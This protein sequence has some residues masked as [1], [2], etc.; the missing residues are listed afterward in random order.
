[1]N[2]LLKFITCGS[3]D[4]GKSTLIGRMLCDAKLIFKEQEAALVEDS[5]QGSAGDEIDY[6]LLLDGLTAEREQG[7]TIDV[8]YRY[9][10]TD[11]RSFI[12]ADTPGHEEY[13]RNMAVGASFC[14]LAII[15]VDA[16][17]GILRQT[18]RHTRICN[19]M[20][21]RNFVFAINKMDLV[22]YKKSVFE[23][24]RHDIYTLMES[25]NY[26]SLFTIP[27]AASKGDNITRLSINMLWYESIPLLQYL[28]TVDVAVTAT[29]KPFLMTVQ[30]VSRPDHTFRG[31]QGQVMQG[32]LALNDAVYIFPSGETADIKQILLMDKDVVAVDTQQAVTLVLDREVDCSRGCVITKNKKQTIGRLFR[33][34]LL[35]MDDEE[36]IVGRNYLLKVGTKVIPATII[37]IHYC[38]NVNSGKHILQEQ[39][40]KND[41]INC[42]VS[43]SE[44]VVLDKFNQTPELGRF[45][46]INRIT[47]MTAACGVIEH[48]L[49]RSDNL[50]WQ[51]L[52][53]TKET[54][55]LLKNQTPKTIW[56]TGLSGSGKSTLANAL[57][58]MLAVFGKHTMLLDGDNIR[59]GLNNNLGF[60]EEDRVE[61]IRRI[62]EVSKLL[63]DAGIIVLVAAISPFEKDRENAKNIIGKDFVEIYVNTSLEECEK[64]DTKGL[65]QKARQGEISKFTGISSPY[66]VPASPDFIADTQNNSVEEI[67]NQILNYLNY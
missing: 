17:K 28:E 29:E 13:T 27:I 6:A 39:A 2:T 12:V 8:A 46:L 34:N 63:N 61:N 32:K 45:I 10:S 22:N 14:D 59:I 21:I 48:I 23:N 58:K 40:Q 26:Q 47:N 3:V 4:D 65:Y 51:N 54:R 5:K 55:S 50:T 19:L 7:I 33:T 31:F 20:G 67:I 64:R 11:R 62:A 66:E 24:I 36:L 37:K 42:D 43:L 9:F 30:R 15:L 53:V 52:D 44:K 49:Y 38:V 35:W 1:M 57:E 56:F 25:F 18:K 16:T 41:L 60:S